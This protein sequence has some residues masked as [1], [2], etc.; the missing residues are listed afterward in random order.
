MTLV[1]EGACCAIRVA[2]RSRVTAKVIGD[3]SFKFSGKKGKIWINVL[4]DM[5]SMS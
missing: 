2:G 1:H 3:D 5:T 4:E